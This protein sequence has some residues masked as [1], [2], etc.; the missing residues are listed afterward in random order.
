MWGCAV[1]W[2]SANLSSLRPSYHIGNSPSAQYH[3]IVRP[4]SSSIQNPIKIYPLNPVIKCLTHIM[5]N[6][7]NPPPINPRAQDLRA[8]P[9]IHSLHK[10]PLFKPRS[11]TC[12]THIPR[13]G[14]RKRLQLHMFPFVSSAAHSH[15]LNVLPI[16]STR[17]QTSVYRNEYINYNTSIT[18]DSGHC[19]W[20]RRSS[21]WCKGEDACTF[22]INSIHPFSHL[23]RSLPTSH[24]HI[25]WMLL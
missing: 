1:I 15:L 21:A 7:N 4:H 14:D 5:Y 3:Y 20:S 6:L 22:P 23:C 11:R 24:L 13:S 19:K 17:N 25:Q 16:D 12:P 18:G 8:P 10:P 2:C 9:I